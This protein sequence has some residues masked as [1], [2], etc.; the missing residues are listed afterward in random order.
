MLRLL[1]S[2]AVCVVVLAHPAYKTLIPN[3]SNVLNPCD[4]SA[5]P[6]VGHQNPAGTGAR[7]QFGID[8][9]AANHTWTLA[10]CRLDSDGDGKTNGEE[11]GD[12]NCNW[13]A[14]DPQAHVDPVQG[15]PGVCEPVGS[16]RCTSSWFDCN[17]HFTSHLP[18]VGR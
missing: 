8:F 15:N 17:M 18:P 14:D 7:N 1:V 4:G 11:L 10:L 16:N 2:A 5:W 6:G 12:A 3:G 9:A 13:T